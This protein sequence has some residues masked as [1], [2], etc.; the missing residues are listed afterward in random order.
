[1]AQVTEWLF[2]FPELLLPSIEEVEYSFSAASAA[3]PWVQHRAVKGNG[4][5]VLVQ[6]SAATKGTVT[7]RVAQAVVHT[8]AIC[9]VFQT[10]PFLRGCL[11]V[12]HGLPRAP[13]HYRNALSGLCLDTNGHYTADGTTVDTWTCISSADNEGFV[14]DK[15]GHL[16]GQNSKK[17]LATTGCAA[18]AGACIQPCGAGLHLW[19]LGPKDASGQVTISSKGSGGETKGACLQ[20]G[21]GALGSKV[22]LGPCSSPPSKGQLWTAQQ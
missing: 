1:L 8:E 18:G 3:E 21:A 5:S 20:V 12:Q 2:E 15:A 7:M 11:W 6:T 16:V 4:T 17:C 13:D 22:S 14:M 10:A 9:R 19:A